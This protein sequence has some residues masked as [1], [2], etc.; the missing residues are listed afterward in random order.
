MGK[1]GQRTFYFEKCLL[2]GLVKGLGKLLH[3]VLRQEAGQ[4]DKGVIE[5]TVIWQFGFSK[6]AQRS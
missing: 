3:I 1:V 5:H 2:L 4:Q 6:S